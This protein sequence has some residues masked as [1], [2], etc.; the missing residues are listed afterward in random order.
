M[1]W[2]L[3]LSPEPIEWGSLDDL[4]IHALVAHVSPINFH[5]RTSTM[6]RAWSA[7]WRLLKE[8]SETE[9]WPRLS[10]LQSLEVVRLLNEAYESI[11]EG[12]R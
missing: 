9:V 5:E 7:A 11:P 3:F 1:D 2:W 6:L 10:R 8:V 4:P 12:D